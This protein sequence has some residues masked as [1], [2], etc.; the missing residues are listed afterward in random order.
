MRTLKFRITGQ[1]IKPDGDFTG[2]VR[3]SKGFLKAK[4]DF[5]NEWQGC[6]KAASF[7]KYGREYAV[8]II[9]SEC[10]IPEEALTG[11]CFGVSVTGV[12]NGFRITTNKC[13]VKQE[14]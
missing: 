5:S 9:G 6:K 4:F 7:W 1:N 3:G 10:D 14:G 13:S 8:P 11:I 2:I 12:G